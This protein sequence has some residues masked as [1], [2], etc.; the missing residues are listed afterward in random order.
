[1]FHSIE[2]YAR[3]HVNPNIRPCLCFL[4]THTGV[5]DVLSAWIKQK[6]VLGD[7]LGELW[8]QSQ[9]PC[10]RQLQSQELT[11]VSTLI[12]SLPLKTWEFRDDITRSELTV[13]SPLITSKWLQNSLPPTKGTGPV[14]AVT[15]WSWHIEFKNA[16][17]LAV[18]FLQPLHLGIKWHCSANNFQLS[19]APSW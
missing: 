1:M 5:Q 11:S 18:P 9:L 8:E 14:T 2:G 12:P 4:M 17:C 10:L 13:V 3:T 7:P 19:T 6:C 15:A 16:F